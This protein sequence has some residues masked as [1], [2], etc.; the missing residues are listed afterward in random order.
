MASSRTVIGAP[1]RVPRPTS[2]RVPTPP[3]TELVATIR[4]RSRGGL[5]VSSGS[6]ETIATT[7][8]VRAAR[9]NSMMIVESDQVKATTVPKTPRRLQKNSQKTR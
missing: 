4:R 8:P 5:V 9:E 2:A 1:S 3:R 6:R 7:P